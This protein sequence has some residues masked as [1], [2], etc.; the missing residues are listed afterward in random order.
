MVTPRALATDEIF[1]AS[2]SSSG[3]RPRTPG[4]R[5]ELVAYGVPFIANP[6]LPERFRR[7]APLN[8]ADFSTLYSGE[9]KGY[10][11]YPALR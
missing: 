3:A 6:D 7:E 11:D 4:R 8:T 9:E 5:A 2:S 10:T 1:P